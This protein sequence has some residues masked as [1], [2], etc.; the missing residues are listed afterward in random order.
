MKKMN[1]D[2]KRMNDDIK[3]DAKAINVDILILLTKAQYC[4][5]RKDTLL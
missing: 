3:T 4:L 2:G 1:W 5:C